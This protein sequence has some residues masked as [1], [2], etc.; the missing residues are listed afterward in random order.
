MKKQLNNYEGVVAQMKRIEPQQS[1]IVEISN[2]EAVETVLDQQNIK[3]IDKV[4][5]FIYVQYTNR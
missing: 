3:T 4:I 2:N 1:E 5:E